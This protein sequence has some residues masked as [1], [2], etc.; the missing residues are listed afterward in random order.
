MVHEWCT[1]QLETS[2]FQPRCTRIHATREG[3]IC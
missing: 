2:T 1:P 3:V